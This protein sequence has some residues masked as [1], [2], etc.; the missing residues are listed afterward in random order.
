MI[1]IGNL[2]G[3]GKL[4]GSSVRYLLMSFEWQFVAKCFSFPK[5]P[6]KENCDETS[7]PSVRAGRNCHFRGYH[8]CP[9]RY[10]RTSVRHSWLFPL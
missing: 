1:K 4:F 10:V 2:A 7:S 8:D 3:I 5:K 6:F 9:S